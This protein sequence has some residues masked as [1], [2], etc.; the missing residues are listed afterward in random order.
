MIDLVRVI[1]FLASI[2]SLLDLLHLWVSNIHNWRW[3]SLHIFTGGYQLILVQF[4]LWLALQLS[5]TCLPLSL[6][7]GA[8][9]HRDGIGNWSLIHCLPLLI[10]EIF[11]TNGLLVHLH[12]ILGL[13]DWSLNVQGLHALAD[14]F[15]LVLTQL[16]TCPTVSHIHLLLAIV[17]LESLVRSRWRLGWGLRSATILLTI[18]LLIAESTI[19]VSLLLIV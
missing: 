16:S 7:A 10:G 2:I 1:V 4:Q 18:G 12:E 6:I 5:L 13:L 9:L 15:F 17:R 11:L 14:I 3:Y 19:K 8:L